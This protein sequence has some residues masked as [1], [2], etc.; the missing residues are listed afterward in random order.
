M[1]PGVPTK[2]I[3]AI[4]ALAGFA[5]AVIAGLAA[6]NASS[7]VLVCALTGML[8]CHM[9]GLGVGAIG[10]R[11]VSDHLGTYRAGRPVPDTNRT[12][13]TNHKDSGARNAIRA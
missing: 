2:V 1:Q 11:I 6:G 7:R 8:V 9:L 10:E 5:V 3:A 12:A 13:S 4:F